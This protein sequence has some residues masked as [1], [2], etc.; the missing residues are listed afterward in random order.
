MTTQVVRRELKAL[1][2]SLGLALVPHGL[3]KNAVIALLEA[4]CTVA[5]TA[6]ITGQTFN[7]V[8]QYARQVDQRRLGDAA[9]LKFENKGGTR[10]RIGKPLAKAAE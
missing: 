6:A 4:G 1:G 7:M 9:I 8:E 2:E 5:E 3:R 10:K